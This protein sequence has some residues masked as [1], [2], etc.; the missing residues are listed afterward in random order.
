MERKRSCIPSQTRAR[1]DFLH[2]DEDG[3]NFSSHSQR[4][5]RGGRKEKSSSEGKRCMCV[6]EAEMCG[7]C[8]S[9]LT[10]KNNTRDYLQPGARFLQTTVKKRNITQMKY[11]QPQSANQGSYAMKSTHHLLHQ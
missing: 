6:C 5:E 8:Q 4:V 11:P 1:M 10:P 3:A 7:A 2:Q 9:V